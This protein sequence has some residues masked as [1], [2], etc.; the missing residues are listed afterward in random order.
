MFHEYIVVLM[1][2]TESPVRYYTSTGG[3]IADTSNKMSEDSV[4][5][6]T[7]SVN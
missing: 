6:I 4:L 7:G 2:E 1:C 3:E 5:T